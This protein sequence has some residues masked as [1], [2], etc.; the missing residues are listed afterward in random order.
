MGAN[1]GGL[2]RDPIWVG[3]DWPDIS[4][5]TSISVYDRPLH[6]KRIVP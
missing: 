2:T 4:V 5:S 3:L 6:I 1:G